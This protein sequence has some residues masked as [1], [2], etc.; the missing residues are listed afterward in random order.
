MEK[1]QKKK[2]FNEIK[3]FKNDSINEGRNILSNFSN[4]IGKESRKKLKK[5][6]V[7]EAKNMF[8]SFKSKNYFDLF[9]NKNFL[10]FFNKKRYH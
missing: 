1:S 6:A 9:K 10:F 7:D 2:I 3:T 4:A 5:D 8:N